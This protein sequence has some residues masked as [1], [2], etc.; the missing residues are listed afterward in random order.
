[1]KLLIRPKCQVEEGRGGERGHQATKTSD[2]EELVN[3]QYARS[4]PVM[5]VGN[6]ERSIMN[7]VRGNDKFIVIP[8]L[9]SMVSLKVIWK[10]I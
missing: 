6:Y 9:M 2:M 10:E 8:E 4:K 7:S 3:G 1:M 5:M